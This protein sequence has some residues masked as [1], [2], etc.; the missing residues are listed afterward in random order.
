M[1]EFRLPDIGEGVVEG[2]VVKW[3]VKQGDTVREDQPMVEVMTD[4]ATVEIPSPKAG[5]IKEIR[6]QEGK[7]CAVGA[8]M[9]VIEEN[10]VESRESRVQSSGSEPQ[11]AKE[12]RQFLDK[13]PKSEPPSVSNVLQLSTLNSQL[14]TR[15]GKVL[16]T[17]ATR[18]L[19]RDLGV[20]LA[21]VHA[22]GP[23]GRV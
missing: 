12:E 21:A 4:K 9:V 8:V 10:A 1:F 14:S 5:L 23:N 6:A 3:H 22:T 7:L 20:D 2:E 15:S 13:T 19:A 16:A 18:K 11:T 17:P